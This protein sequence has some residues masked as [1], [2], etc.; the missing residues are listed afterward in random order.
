[1]ALANDIIGPLERHARDHS[2]KKYLYELNTL[3]DLC[4]RKQQQLEYALRLVEGLR[5]GTG[6]GA[7]LSTLDEK[8]PSPATPLPVVSKRKAHKG[9]TYRLTLQLYKDGLSV[10]QIAAQRD[11]AMS[12]IEGHLAGFILT[13][14]IALCELVPEHKIAPITAAIQSIGGPALSPIWTLLGHDYSFG[15]IRAVLNYLKIQPEPTSPSTPPTPSI[16]S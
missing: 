16:P 11:M 13:G 2:S 1:L 5:H 15:E 7:L 12:T 6:T 14:D 4:A 8:I 10:E 9:D 3:N